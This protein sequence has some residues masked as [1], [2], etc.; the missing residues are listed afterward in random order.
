LAPFAFEPRAL[1]A[2]QLGNSPQAA[3]V[4]LPMALTLPKAIIGACTQLTESQASAT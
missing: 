2:S 3:C 4:P 1:A